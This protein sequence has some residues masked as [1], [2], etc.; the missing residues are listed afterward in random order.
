MSSEI[1]NRASSVI[2]VENISPLYQEPFTIFLESGHFEEIKTDIEVENVSTSKI[3]KIRN[4]KQN[5]P[6]GFKST[7]GTIY[8]VS[9]MSNASEFQTVI[10]FHNEL[11]SHIEH[12]KAFLGSH[13]RKVYNIKS[14]SNIASEN[15]ILLDYVARNALFFKF[16]KKQK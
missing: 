9:N 3:G 15:D 7:C 6:C 12:V 14:E 10:V 8:N 5:V 4:K 11:I 2:V 16:T 1:N 13:V